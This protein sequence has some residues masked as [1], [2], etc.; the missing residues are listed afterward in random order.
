MRMFRRSKVGRL[1]VAL[2]LAF[3]LLVPL[4]S[5]EIKN[6][7]LGEGTSWQAYGQPSL[8]DSFSRTLV[9][10]PQPSLTAFGDFDG[11]GRID[12]AV[13]SPTAT[14]V[15]IYVQNTDG[16]F[17]SVP[18]VNISIPNAPTGLAS[19]YLD[20]DG[21]IDLAVA[22]PN[23]LNGLLYLCYQREG[24]AANHTYATADPPY[25]V[26]IRDFDNDGKNDVA[27]VQHSAAGDSG[28]FQLFRASRAF[29]PVTY[30]QVPGLPDPRYPVE[31]CTTDLN[32]DGRVDMVLTDRSTDRVT[33]FRNDNIFSAVE[34]VIP[35]QEINATNGV[36]TP[37]GTYC[38]QMDG[39]GPEELIITSQSA[40]K[41]RI[42]QYS[43]NPNIGYSVAIPWKIVYTPADTL[44]SCA[45]NVSGGARP[46]VVAV[47]SSSIANIYVTP[48][49]GGGYKTE[50]DWRFPVQDTPLS[51]RSLDIDGD[52]DED[53]AIT[54][55]GP[56]GGSVTVY[57]K[58]GN[59]LSNAD[60]N[61]F[62]PSGEIFC[63][64]T[65]GDYD[66]NGASE[67][68]TVV[69]N[70]LVRLHDSGSASL[71]TKE[72]GLLPCRIL[73]AELTN[74]GFDDLILLNHGSSTVM[75]Y[76]GSSEFF[77][78]VSYSL[79]LSLNLSGP[80]SLDVGDFSGDGLEDLV[81]GCE[82]GFQVIYN[83][84]VPPFF[85]PVHSSTI[86]LPGT[87]VSW[88]S[89]ANLD[90]GFEDIGQSRLTDVAI[91]NASSNGVEVFLQ[92]SDRSLVKSI[93]DTLVPPV[94]GSIMWMDTGLLNGDQLPDIAIA[95]DTGT[96]V[97][98]WQG[99]GYGFDA[100]THDR[101]T[102]VYGITS[103]S[104]GDL[105]D[106]GFDELAILGSSVGVVTVY[107]RTLDRYSVV[108]NFTSGGDGGMVRTL[109]SDGDGRVDIVALSPRSNAVS[110]HIQSNVPPVA[111]AN[112][113]DQYEIEGALVRFEA[114]NSTDGVSDRHL[115]NYTWEF[116]GGS[117]R[118]GVE[119]SYTFTN[120]DHDVLL[121]V[122][123]P[124]GLASTT[125]VRV[126][127]TDFTPVASF[128]PTSI[129]VLEG[130][131]IQFIDTTVPG[132]DSIVGWE[133]SFGDG[134]Y[135]NEQN[136]V[137]NYSRNGTYIVTLTVHDSDG[138][139]DST[140]GLVTVTDRS[141]VPSIEGPDTAVE[142]T[143]VAFH[144][145]AYSY[146]DAVTNWT[147]DFGD[148][149]GPSYVKDP[150]HQFLQNGTYLVTLTVW[151]SDSFSLTVK[152]IVISDTVPQVQYL[153]S[154]DAVLEGE[155]I[156]FTDLTDP[157]DRVGSR[158]WNFGD[159]SVSTDREVS[160]HYALHGQ[161]TVTLT[162]VDG[163]GT[164]GQAQFVINVGDIA[165]VAL[166]NPQGNYIEGEDIVF[167]DI[168]T[169][170][171]T[172][173]LSWSWVFGDGFRSTE[174]SPVH[175]FSDNG[176]YWV[177]LTVTDSHGLTSSHNLTLVISDTTPTTSDIQ[178]GGTYNEDEP[179]I[180]RA[181]A[182][183]KWGPIVRFE[184]DFDLDPLNLQGSFTN[185]TWTRQNQTTHSF[186]SAG[187]YW[188]GVKVWDKDSSDFYCIKVTVVN[189]APIADFTFQPL[190]NGSVSF[191]AGLS[192]DTSSDDNSLQ[193]RWN[194][195][196]LDDEEWT[197]WSPSFTA[198]KKF[199]VDGNYTVI[200]EVRDPDGKVSS[201]SKIVTV[202]RSD[203]T[204][205]SIALSDRVE[206]VNVDQIIQIR[207][208]VTDNTGVFSVTLFYSIGGQVYSA[209]MTRADGVDA[210]IG[211]IPAQNS[212][213]EITYW[214]EALDIGNNLEQT[215][216]FN[217]R[218]ER[219]D[220]LP[221]LVMAGIVA[222]SLLG[223]IL[224]YRAATMVVD[225][226]FVIYSDGNLIAHQTRRLKPGMD[227][228]V[229]GSMLVAVQSFVKDSFK[230]ES[231]TTLNRLDFGEK[232]LLIERGDYLVLAAVLHGKREG[233]APQRLKELVTRAESDYGEALRDWD[234]DLEKL[235]GIKDE[236]NDLF[237][238]RPAEAIRGLTKGSKND[239]IDPD[240]AS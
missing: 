108:A 40:S 212:T 64:L 114:H 82:G 231:S 176:S 209:P 219:D 35:I 155:S 149:S 218:V 21:N 166:F 174:Q 46:D 232:K 5:H 145:L 52:L 237:R 55:S 221:L 98:F 164:I 132:V 88:V 76:W 99:E 200:L 8:F 19:G 142:G 47:T 134:K 113:L 203:R 105:D 106:D 144:G 116:G 45:L 128:Q 107:D 182:T 234:G 195:N 101:L 11:D 89:F 183:A 119:T 24:F 225:E 227:D 188:V 63:D 162:V 153:V 83:T 197:S 211:E 215:G 161:Y 41:V 15:K 157:Y 138:S 150:I 102:A 120:G 168:S 131:D 125:T 240:N 133:W 30:H 109:D 62:L 186:P 12:V 220:P 42:Y 77:S 178:G 81:V 171:P 217:L 112:C 66:G 181:D 49:G 213:G 224:Y 94:A 104:C 143:Y 239:G 92:R 79:A 53:L 175:R 103:S 199:P 148:G 141:P 207:A 51:G 68:A 123:D 223:G 189:L 75:F 187:I 23:G 147:W 152:N 111:I 208:S 235:R 129:S 28:G 140:T 184:W 204:K 69:S 135:S 1:V 163:D 14:I 194:F 96:L 198:S 90:Y 78:N 127:V 38:T 151:D 180:F 124:G 58:A 37:Y 7:P 97:T 2:A 74:D 31:I 216:V 84:G 18:T 122:R 214:I 43:G 34:T 65:M 117:V 27:V 169:K 158:S 236:T 154:A 126:Y 56:G 100:Y 50:P 17:Q 210:W 173:T 67:L 206:V 36:S 172:A 202:D 185:Q 222:L 29:S 73:T 95:L 179:V 80:L 44:F 85:D 26:V 6:G 59:G 91:V 16:S 201:V 121:T 130:Q 61:V 25:G 3:V 192:Y 160:H 39:N 13:G 115:L 32:S 57:F 177:N 118:Y 233:K 137:S 165:P 33:V 193:Y 230:D 71:C 159:G 60:L 20:S 9:T 4:L 136:P 167:L 70:G 191:D 10:N 48:D 229:L 196:D 156:L 87:N 72:A 93:Y 205:P 54:S 22:C 139:Y 86:F 238:F 226:V 110:I 190:G 146:P 228:D 170:S